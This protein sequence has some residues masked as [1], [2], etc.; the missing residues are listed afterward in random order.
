MV[1]VLKEEMN[2]SHKG[3]YEIGNEQLKE[4]NETVQDLKMEV[5]ENTT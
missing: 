2:K 4:T 3:I 1:D 5:K